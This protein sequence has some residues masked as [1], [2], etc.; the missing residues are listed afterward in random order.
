MLTLPLNS[1][2]LNGINAFFVENSIHFYVK[3]LGLDNASEAIQFAE[4]RYKWA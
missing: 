1:N 2:S 3:H 4:T